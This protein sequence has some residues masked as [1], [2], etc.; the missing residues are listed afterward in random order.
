MQ[1]S[2]FLK[3]LLTV[4]FLAMALLSCRDEG[5][6]SNPSVNLEFSTDSLLFDTVFTTVGSSTRSFKVYNK[7]NRRINISSVKLAGGNQ[8]YFRI[9]VD[10]ASGTTLRDIEIDA[11]DSIFIFVE[12]TVDPVKQ[13]LPLIIVDSV[14]FDT[15]SNIQDV[16]LA[17]WGQDAHFIYPNY[18]DPES[19]FQFHLITE[20]STWTSDLPYVVYGLAIVAPEIT[21]NIEEGARV[22]FHNN[23]SLIFLEGATLKANGSAEHPIRFQGDRLED[24]FKDVA[25]QWGR[26][27][28]FATSKDHEINYAIIKNGT[29]GLHVDTIGS[30][31]APT[32]SI[33]N[34]VIK[35]M[36][37][38]GLFAQGSHV[39][40]ENM[41]I[42]DCGE[43]AAVL[44]L[45]GTYDFKHCT[46]ANYHSVSNRRTPTLVL[47]NYYEDIDGNIQIRE[48]ENFTIANSI[49]YGGL[50]EE[51]SLD[52]Y[53]GTDPSYMFD[54][55]LLRTQ[56]E[57]NAP[58]FVNVLKNMNPQFRNTLLGDYRLKDES[59]AIGAGNAGISA[60]VPFDILGNDRS[61]RSD[62]GA[63]QYYEVEEE[64]EADK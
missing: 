48:M 2:G 52:F 43:H 25:G 37:I 24:F 61:E 21:L 23:S 8:S 41:I 27:W 18:Q 22:H 15:N 59:P 10:G 47:N 60:A 26:I 16:K 29:V 32:L 34:T 63:I 1:L 42:T 38:A 5:I 31:S 17:A 20:N 36:S 44:A 13:Q 45:G 46:F 9:N 56:I 57:G 53:P 58:R 6:D 7:H 55:C 62:L 19:G 54:H 50:Q 39:V 35:N 14:V 40:A 28:F 11:R 3:S 51:I 64:E 30:S 12:V 33:R 49:I 4:L